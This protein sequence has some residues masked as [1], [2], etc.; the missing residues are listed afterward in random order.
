MRAGLLRKNPP[1]LIASGQSTIAPASDCLERAAARNQLLYVRDA[2]RQI[3]EFMKGQRQTDVTV[4]KSGVP[5]VADKVIRKPTTVF[6]TVKS[7]RAGL[8]Q[9]RRQLHARLLAATK[10]GPN[11]LPQRCIEGVPGSASAYPP[12]YT[13]VPKVAKSGKNKGNT[14]YVM[15]SKN[16]SGVGPNEVAGAT[17]GM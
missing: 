11:G 12:G 17:A 6:L 14:Y 8:V 9:A 15:S 1:D 7:R 2:Q 16:G 4:I 10:L 5:G 13:S 3:A